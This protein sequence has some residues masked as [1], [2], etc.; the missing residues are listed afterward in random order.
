M[1]DANESEDRIELLENRVHKL[2]GILQV[3]LDELA[4]GS[5]EDSA[6]RIREILD[7]DEQGY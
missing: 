5:I 6:S 1:T 7:L 2:E 4:N 3:M